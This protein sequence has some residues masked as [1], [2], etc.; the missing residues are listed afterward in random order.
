MRPL[1][2]LTRGGPGDRPFS[3]A[4]VRLQT[5]PASA[6]AQ[7]RSSSPNVIDMSVP[8]GRTSRELG[9]ALSGNDESAGKRRSGRAR[10]GTPLAQ[11]ALR[12]GLGRCAH[13]D[14]YINA[15]S[16]ASGGASEPSRGKALFAVAHTLV[17]IIWNVLA[18]TRPPMW[19]SA[20]TVPA[21]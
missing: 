7:L 20:R 4:V 2:S 21:A 6:F 14:T 16:V 3:D 15:Q 19:T 12:G 17:V 13:R 8:D 10:K 1:P 11:C 5:I 9:R 18:P